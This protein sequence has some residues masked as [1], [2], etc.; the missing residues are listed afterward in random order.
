MCARENKINKVSSEEDDMCEKV[1]QVSALYN[2]PLHK[3]GISN[4]YRSIYVE[5]FFR[6]KVYV[7]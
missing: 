6:I 5:D 7:T 2:F 1:L 4:L 3:L